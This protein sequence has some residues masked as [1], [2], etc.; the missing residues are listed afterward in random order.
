MVETSSKYMCRR[1]AIQSISVLGAGVGTLST[2]VTASTKSSKYSIKTVESTDTYKINKVVTGDEELFMRIYT[3][4]SKK[5]QIEHLERYQNKDGKSDIRLNSNPVSNEIKDT[6]VVRLKELGGSLN[7]DCKYNYCSGFDYTHKYGGVTFELTDFAQ[8]LSYSA[9]TAAILTI[10]ENISRSNPQS[11]IIDLIV[12]QVLN[13][14]TGNTFTWIPRDNDGF[15]GPE[16]QHCVV[17]GWNKD[18][19][20]I[21]SIASNMG[22]GHLVEQFNPNCGR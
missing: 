16:V 7:E 14:L 12:G 10:V 1:K 4:G 11:W 17:E 9:L 13:E 5:G 21:D 19:Q 22:K 6:I 15:Y 2:P 8:E 18:P 3:N 20:E